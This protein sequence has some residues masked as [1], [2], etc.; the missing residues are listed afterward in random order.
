MTASTAR[1]RGAEPGGRTR[2]GAVRAGVDRGRPA[3]L[4]D[5]VVQ[6]VAPGAAADGYWTAMLPP[7][8]PNRALILGLGGGTVARLLVER[9]GDVPV[10]GVDDDPRVL[11]VARESFGPLPPFVQAVLADALAFVLAPRL[12]G[13]FGYIAVDLFRG[14]DMPRG[15][16]G[17]PFLRAVRRALT[18]GGA[19]AFNLFQ[20][21]FTEGRLARI[22]AV[23][24]PLREERV[25]GNL[26]V[27]R[28]RG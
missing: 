17:R 3:V 18:P 11:A 4:V 13:R 25:R 23:F 15:A 14:A 27:W 19:V 9:F 10:V 7:N 2:S 21:R 12:A 1:G 8:R 20:D 16:F 6:S 5:G 26:I 24:R 28:G 22:D